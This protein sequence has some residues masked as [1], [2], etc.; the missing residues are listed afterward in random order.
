MKNPPILIRTIAQK[1]NHHFT[2]EWTDGSSK[3]YRLSDLQRRCPC[4]KCFDVET[5]KQRCTEDEPD[6]D[7]R[8]VQIK[9]VGRYALKVLFTSGCS[10]GIYSYDMLHSWK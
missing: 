2:V 4:A 6:V 8:A 3:N 10:R 9:S 1:D 5:G 7:V